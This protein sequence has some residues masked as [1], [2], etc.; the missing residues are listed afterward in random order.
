MT[1]K[2]LREHYVETA[3]SFLGTRMGDERHK[4]IIDTYNEA[5]K[6][7]SRR[8]RMNY[9][10][11]YCIAFCSAIAVKSGVSDIYPLECGVGEA[12]KI[13]VSMGIWNEEDACV[14]K[15]GDLVTFN[16]SDPGSGDNQ[17]WPN[18]VAIVTGTD[19]EEDV[20]H[21]I[22]PND[23]RHEVSEWSVPIDGKNIRGFI[24]PDYAALADPEYP[25]GTVITDLYIRTAPSRV[26]Q[27]CNIELQ[28]GK[29]IRNVL[30]RGER[31]LIIG[32][33]N[34]WYQ[35]RCVGSRYIWEPWCSGKYVKI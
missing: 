9:E 19:L 35:I 7:F 8:Y 32:E 31:V 3:R 27:K 33:H 29:G 14:P 2:E 6:P 12:Q 10:D 26:A 24:L 20:I 30:R 23:R 16:W 13:A 4:D 25:V 21:L 28:D 15:P 22:N 34:G 18:H 17:G 5:Y 11:S 1:E